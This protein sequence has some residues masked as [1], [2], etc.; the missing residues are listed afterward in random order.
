MDLKKPPPEDSPEYDAW[1]N[2]YVKEF[3]VNMAIARPAIV[4]HV[5]ETKRE[6]SFV[7]D[8]IPCPI[9]EDGTLHYT[10]HGHYNRHIS[11]KCTTED[12]IEWIE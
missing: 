3:L 2:E 1:L 6:K 10:Y 8:K 7:Q 12:C 4:A 9:R 5:K 11:A